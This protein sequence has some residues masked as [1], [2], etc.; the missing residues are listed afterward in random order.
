MSTTVHWRPN[1]TS[2]SRSSFNAIV[3]RKSADVPEILMRENSMGQKAVMGPN[4]EPAGLVSR[5]TAELICSK[6]NQKMDKGLSNRSQS[7]PSR[8]S[9]D[10]AQ[11]R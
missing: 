10:R 11:D 4:W 8:I 3:T 7:Q 1:E 5:Y 6:K 9:T 2:L